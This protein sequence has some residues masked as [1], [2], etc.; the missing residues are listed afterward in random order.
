MNE[1][2]TFENV[3]TDT[4]HSKVNFGLQQLYLIG[5]NFYKTSFKNYFFEE[6]NKKNFLGLY[7][8]LPLHPLLACFRQ[9]LPYKL[10]T[11]IKN[12]TSNEALKITCALDWNGVKQQLDAIDLNTCRNQLMN[13]LDITPQNQESNVTIFHIAQNH[14]L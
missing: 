3:F 7:D 5:K 8:D 2:H 4:Q 9:H 12:F 11:K 13:I 6:K 1:N 14:L 10:F